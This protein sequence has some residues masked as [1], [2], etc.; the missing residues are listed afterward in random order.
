[1]SEGAI[2]P[3]GPAVGWGPRTQRE[4]SLDCSMGAPP[5]SERAPK[6]LPSLS[7]WNWSKA[8]SELQRKVTFSPDLTTGPPWAE[9]EGYLDRP[10][11]PPLGEKAP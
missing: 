11:G 9:R 8:L 6:V 3:V 2:A 4:L 1:M 10:G 7:R 5:S